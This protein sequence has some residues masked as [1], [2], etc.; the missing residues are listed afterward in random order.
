MLKFLKDKAPIIAA[1]EAGEPSQAAFMNLRDELQ[2]AYERIRELERQKPPMLIMPSHADLVVRARDAETR[3]RE[4]EAKV[5]S[6]DKRGN[7]LHG[8]IATLHGRIN[9]LEAQLKDADWGASYMNKD[10][11]SRDARIREL[12]HFIHFSP[13]R[14]DY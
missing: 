9:E 5:A 6:K 13:K 11:I 14:W 10:I 8:I 2:A 4:L 1:I 7:E 3:V 12:E